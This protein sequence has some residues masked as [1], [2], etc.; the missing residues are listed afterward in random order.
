MAAKND[1]VVAVIPARWASE[2]FPGKVLVDLCGKPMIQWVHERVSQASRI[3]EVWVATEDE[4][5]ARCVEGFGGRVALTSP[6]H[7]TGTDR[8]AEAVRGLEADWILNVQGD[9][10]LVPPGDL[11]RL[12]E[13]MLADF[14]SNS[15]AYDTAGIRV[16]RPAN[17]DQQTTQPSLPRKGPRLAGGRKPNGDRVAAKNPARNRQ[18]HGYFRP[19]LA[20]PRRPGIG[21]CLIRTTN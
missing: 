5:V 3:A 4:R 14:A 9:E 7:A 6:D 2:R 11:D 19:F 17:A 8:V 10:P 21:G 20:C 16:P 13:A 18:K 12:I 15:L 1:R